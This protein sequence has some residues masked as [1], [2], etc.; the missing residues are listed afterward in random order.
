M[1]LTGF[2]CQ[3]F[4]FLKSQPLECDIKTTDQL[5][6]ISIMWFSNFNAQKEMLHFSQEIQPNSCDFNSLVIVFLCHAFHTCLP[7]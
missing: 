7:I 2:S 6:E 4:Q 1:F 5:L 3:S